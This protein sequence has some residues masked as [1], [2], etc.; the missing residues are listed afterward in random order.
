[1]KSLGTPVAVEIR[2]IAKRGA[3]DAEWTTLAYVWDP[4]ETA[5]PLVEIDA[6]RTDH[7]VPRLPA[8]AG[9]AA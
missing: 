9:T 4:D 8:T 1:L 3:T 7:D 6:H 5:A 2:L